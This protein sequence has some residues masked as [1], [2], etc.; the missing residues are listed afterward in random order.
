[1]G[2]NDI[3]N[4]S[5][6]NNSINVNSVTDNLIIAIT[7][8]T[9]TIFEYNYIIGENYQQGINLY[10]YINKLYYENPYDMYDTGIN[11]ETPIVIENNICT[12][13]LYENNIKI[14]VSENNIKYNINENGAI[15]LID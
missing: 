10:N 4:T 3:T 14:I 7:C 11:F 8:E 15:I 6:S 13:T 12:Y 9:Q 2:E 1:M 5:V